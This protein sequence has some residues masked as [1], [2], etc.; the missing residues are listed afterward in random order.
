MKKKKKKSN[1]LHNVEHKVQPI[2]RN[3]LRNNF[4]VKNFFKH[5]S[6]NSNFELSILLILTKNPNNLGEFFFFFFFL[7]GGWGGGGGGRL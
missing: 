2:F 4:Y 3:M 5:K 1:H 7:G 6:Y